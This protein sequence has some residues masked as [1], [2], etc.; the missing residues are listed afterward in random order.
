MCLVHCVVDILYMFK[1]VFDNLEKE[2]KTFRKQKSTRLTIFRE[3]RGTCLI[4][5]YSSNLLTVSTSVKKSSHAFLKIGDG[6]AG[7]NNVISVV[8]QFSR[9]S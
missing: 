6:S 1:N 2:L 5:T 9:M 8:S 3:I 4:F 7:I